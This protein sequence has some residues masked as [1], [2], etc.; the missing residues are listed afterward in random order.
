VRL[1]R[2]YHAGRDHAHRER[3]RALLR[4]GVEL[5]LVVPSTW[6][7]SGAEA[8]LSPEPF[9]IVELP[10]RRAGD[11]NRYTYADGTA[12]REL[13]R[14]RRPDVVDVHEEPFSAAMRQALGAVGPEQT[15]VGYAAQNLDKRWPPPFA[16]WETAALGRLQGLY[17]CTLQAASV[18]VGKGFGGAVAILPLATSMAMTPGEQS[19]PAAELRLL[20]VGRLVPEKGVLDAV[21]VLAAARHG[22]EA[23]LVLVGAGPEADRAFVLATALGVADGLVLLPWLGA[24][25]LAE[26]YRRAHVVLVPSHS[27]RTWVEQFGRTAVEARA[28]GAVVVAYDSGSLAEVVGDGG[29]VVP[30]GDET[31]LVEAVLALRRDPARWAQ[32]RAR[33]LQLAPAA[34]WDAVARGQVDLYERAVAVRGPARRVRPARTAAC[35]RFGPPATA[36]GVERPHALP[37]L[38][39]GRVGATVVSRLIDA[40]ARSEHP[41]R[42]G[43]TGPLRVVYINHISALSGA[44]LALMGLVRALPDVRA[45]VILGEDGPLR[46]RLSRGGTS[47]EVLELDSRTRNTHRA[48]LLPGVSS[49]RCG[50][51]LVSYTLRLARRIKQLDPDVIH[52]NSMKAG[53]YG[54]VAGRLAGVPVV[55]HLRDRVAP[56]C[57]PAAIV[58]VVRLALRWLPSVVVADSQTTLDTSRTSPGSGATTATEVVGPVVHMHDAASTP[59]RDPHDGLVIGIVGRLASWMGQDVVLRAVAQPG[60]EHVH[61][62]VVGS[63]LFDQQ[64]YKNRL[65][66]IVEELGL[67]GRVTFVGFVDDVVAEL[68]R[69]DVLVH[70]SVRPEPFG[71]A[72]VEGMAAGLAVVATAV[73]APGE[74]LTDDVDGLL[75]PRGDA[76]ALARA[77]GRLAAEPETRRRLG[78]AAVR[79]AQEFHPEVVGPRMTGIYTE[80]VKRRPRGGRWRD[81]FS[82]RRHTGR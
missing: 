28:S 40:A 72:V 63:A 24:G 59:V 37:W 51:L 58:L 9:E 10:V 2:I 61:L 75:V 56:D 30:E 50:L 54:S 53:F 80:L 44:E 13:V 47:V 14:R 38:R 11:I 49:V 25:E 67:Q 66:E 33:G 34:T 77:L 48:H 46:E 43:E 76:V 5:T 79:R 7:D 39:D 45:H 8:M 21:R 65:H 12:L 41:L 35:A 82:A 70:A 22:G 31:A 27:T 19:L 57:L 69:L 74:I 81:A 20:L 3:E 6:P 29:V 32:L 18:F 1:L 62:R 68:A 36:A 4:A 26:Q 60:L 78:A 23:T 64:P 55:W 52:T 17:P 42:S 16:Q 73:G 15:V 71:Q